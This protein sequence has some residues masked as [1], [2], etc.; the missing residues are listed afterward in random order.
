VIVRD[1]RT[2]A[3]RL[4]LPDQGWALSTLAFSPDGR[5][6]LTVAHGDARLW[7]PA[8][9]AELRGFQLGRLAAL[10]WT[11]DGRHLALSDETRV[12][13][14]LDAATGKETRTFGQSLPG[15][16]ARQNLMVPSSVAF[17]PDGKRM[18]VARWDQDVHIW[19]LQSGALVRTL[20]GRLHVAWSPDGRVIATGLGSV[21]KRQEKPLET[22]LWD[23]ETGA[24]LRRLDARP[25]AR[26]SPDGALLAALS[27]GEVEVWEV[28]SGRL[29]GRGTAPPHRPLCVAFSPDGGRLATGGGDASVILWGLERTEERVAE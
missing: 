16:G 12:V 27:E 9:G 13:R 11:P 15:D 28:A 29:L 6:L 20:P 4:R 10:T 22:A 18:A 17:S 3:A 7:D 23:A 21:S 1:A 14:L 2:G 24:E 25:D 5:S 19:D 8:T 26:F